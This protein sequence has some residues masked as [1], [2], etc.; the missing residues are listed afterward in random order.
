[1]VMMMMLLLLLMLGLCCR[2]GGLFLLLWIHLVRSIR[3]VLPIQSRGTALDHVQVWTKTNRRRVD[4]KTPVHLYN[5]R[6]R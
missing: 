4:L 2:E 3:F 6:T 5:E 1:M